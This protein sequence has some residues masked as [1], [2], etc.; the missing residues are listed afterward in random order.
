MKTIAIFNHY[1]RILDTVISK[2]EAVALFLSAPYPLDEPVKIARN[3]FLISG[4]HRV[5]IVDKKYGYIV[6]FNYLENDCEK[7]C[8]VYRE[9]GNFCNCLTACEKIGNYKR[10][11]STYSTQ[12]LYANTNWMFDGEKVF[13]L[14]NI[15]N[16]FKRNKI[17]V[18]PKIVALNIE[19]YA[20]EQATFYHSDTSEMITNCNRNDPLAE[21]SLAMAQSFRNYLGNQK[22][23]EFNNFLR[24]YEVNDLHYFNFGFIKNRPVLIDFAG[25]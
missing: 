7:E 12:Q 14:K 13:N 2:N 6:K 17:K 11:V 25:I 9:S 5:V 22:Y 10:L 1:K 24:K 16:Y 15:R 3:V 20:Y 23:D 4:I 19:L 8:R 18:I 21:Y